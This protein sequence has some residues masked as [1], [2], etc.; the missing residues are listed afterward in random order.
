MSAPQRK[1]LRSEGPDRTTL[2]VRTELVELARE[3]FPLL[4][5]TSVITIALQRFLEEQALKPRMEETARV[6]T[7]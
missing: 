1:A 4:P 7:A 6:P 3:R 2:T 5:V